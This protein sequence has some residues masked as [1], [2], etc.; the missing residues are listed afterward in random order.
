VTETADS[1]ESVAAAAAA[2][3][4][5]AVYDP[6]LANEDLIPLKKQTW[7]SYNN[8]RSGC[9]TCTASADM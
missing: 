7:T 8:P 4:F 2:K 3:P 5:T 1:T 9:P 6:R